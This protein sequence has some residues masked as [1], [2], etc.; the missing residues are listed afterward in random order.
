MKKKISLIMGIMIVLSLII[1]L[2]ITQANST[3]VQVAPSISTVMAGASFSVNVT[4]TNVT[5]LAVWEFQLYYLNAIL[6]CTS[7]LEG[8]FLK[9][10]GN[11]FFASTKNNAYNATHGWLMAGATLIGPVPGVT[12]SGTLAKITFKAKAAGDTPL[13]LIVTTFSD[14]SPPPR[15]PIPFTST[16]GTVRVRLQQY[17]LTVYSA[18]DSPVP[19]VGSHT[20]FDG[21]SVTCSV[22]SPVTEDSIVWICTGWTGTGSVPSSGSGKSTTF[23]ITQNSTIT[24]NWQV[25]AHDVSVINVVPWRTAVGKGYN[26]NINVTVANEGSSSE[27][28]DVTLY[29]NRTVV[30]T[31]GVVLQNGA[32]QIITFTDRKSVV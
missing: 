8:P 19:S 13:N 27:T 24:W 5:D 28:F 18:H 1:P 23:T 16:D 26:C 30:T 17:T 2:N 11:T 14:S 22:T 4:V 10:G 9:Q 25:G 15:H 32:A 29:V 12:G 7:I 20:Y 6:N 31:E 3:T 21:D